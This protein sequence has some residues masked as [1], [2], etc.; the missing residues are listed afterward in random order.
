MSLHVI[1]TG[2]GI[3]ILWIHGFPLCSEVFANQLSIPDARHIAPD[4]PGLCRSEPPKS[5]MTMTDYAKAVISVLDERKIDRAI[6]AGLSMGG[7]VCFAAWR[8]FPKRISGLILI[9]TRETADS[10]D[11]RRGRYESIANVK[12]KGV[13]AV[14]DAMLPKMLSPAA[15]HSTVSGVKRIM[16]AST[17]EGISAALR[18]MAEREDAS[19]LLPKI[20]VPS[21]VIV[22]ENDTITTPADAKRMASRLPDAKLVIIPG[23]AHLS[24]VERPAEFNA[25]V[26][27]FLKRFNVSSR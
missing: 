19:D 6:F 24:N 17:A 1:E 15:Y 23:A 13:S 9:D 4:L 22:G 20:S 10:D 11:T 7:Y 3:P 8:L 2:S 27:E 21:L 18:G 26:I 14:V 12:Q 5:D 16:S 25:A